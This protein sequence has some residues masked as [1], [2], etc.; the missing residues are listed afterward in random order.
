MSLSVYMDVHVP[1]GPSRFAIEDRQHSP[2]GF[3]PISATWRRDEVDVKS[4]LAGESDEIPVVGKTPAVDVAKLIEHNPA[5][6]AET[7]RHLEQLDQ[8]LCCE[9]AGQG[10][11]WR[12]WGMLL[13][14]GKRVDGPWTTDVGEDRI[15][16]V[17]GKSVIGTHQKSEFP[18]QLFGD[19]G[20]EL[21]K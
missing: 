3:L 15:Q 5:P 11:T 19:D 14:I 4:L 13:H 6:G 21:R 12:L 1:P 8:L 17:L 9:T 20:I 7:S 18:S 16:V 2:D 10:L